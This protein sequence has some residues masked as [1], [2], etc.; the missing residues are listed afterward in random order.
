MTS[1]AAVLALCR[2]GQDAAALLLWGA[3]AYL[4]WLVPKPLASEVAARIRRGTTPA[5]VVALLATLAK[6][7]VEAAGIGD[8]WRDGVDPTTLLAVLLETSV[9]EAWAAQALAAA[10]LVLVQAAPGPRRVTATAL[11]SGL[12]LASL[13]L[14]GHAAMHDGALGLLHR[15]NDAAHLLCAGAWL[16]AL[17]PVLVILDRLGRGE[18]RPEA[19]IAL[20]A[21]SRAGH[22]AVALVL[23]SGAV[24]TAL[25]LGRW[26]TDPA[27][28]YQMLLDVKLLC[29]AT[30][31]GLALAN[32]Y[33][34]VPRLAR[35]PAAA[36]ALRR[37]TLAE[38]ALGLL[39]LALVSV[40]GLL[41]PV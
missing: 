31:V 1:T 17:W 9:G 26:P 37:A 11:A 32:R 27:S 7:P 6:L 28:L 36:L 14:G 33:L 16:G 10:L 38:I 12:L 18:G 25:V 8:G 20:L 21:F 13:S 3:S 41:D 34:V 40:F 23:V 15:A 4:A 2:F 39:V 29:V 5:V 22:V 35:R 19:G 24:N 30:M